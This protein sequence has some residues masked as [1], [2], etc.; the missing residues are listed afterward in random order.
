MRFAEAFGVGTFTHVWMRIES[1]PAV[2][3]LNLARRCVS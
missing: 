3:V 1:N 2:G